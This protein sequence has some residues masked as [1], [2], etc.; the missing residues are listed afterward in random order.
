MRLEPVIGLIHPLPRKLF[1]TLA[2]TSSNEEDLLL[3][4]TEEEVVITEQESTTKA[5]SE[6]E[7]LL[8]KIKKQAQE[9]KNQVEKSTSLE[10]LERKTIE[11]KREPVTRGIFL[12]K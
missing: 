1:S 7:S 12:E 3:P 6:K 2:A 4:D 10:P 9:K 8:N 11:S 5:G